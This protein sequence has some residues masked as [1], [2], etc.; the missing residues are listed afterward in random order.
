MESSEKL[1][2]LFVQIFDKTSSHDQMLAVASLL[3]TWPPL[4]GEHHGEGAWYLVLSKLITDAKDGSAVV[5][6][7]REKADC[8]QLNEKV[9]NT[10]PLMSSIFQINVIEETF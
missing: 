9:R 1:H 7:A 6:I 3:S 5:K 8:M 4:E 2:E 10:T